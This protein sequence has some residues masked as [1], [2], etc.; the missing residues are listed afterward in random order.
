MDYPDVLPSTGSNSGINTHWVLFKPSTET[1][2]ELLGRYLTT[3]FFSGAGGWDVMGIDNFSGEYGMK[4]FLAHYA[5]RVLNGAA[6]GVLPRCTYGNDNHAPTGLDANGDSVCYDTGDCQD[7][8]DTPMADVKVIKMI[9][10]CG[11]PWECSFDESWDAK[12]KETCEG[13]HR[14]WFE[15]RA[16]FEETCWIGSPPPIKRDGDFKKDIFLGYCSCA[17]PACYETMIHDNPTAEPTSTPSSS[18]SLR[19]SSSPTVKPKYPPKVTSNGQ[20]GTAG[21]LPST[22][23]NPSFETKGPVFAAENFYMIMHEDNLYGWDTTAYDSKVEVWHAGFQREQSGAGREP[24]DGEY[25]VEL[26]ANEPAALWQKVNTAGANAVTIG[27]AHGQRGST[28]EQISVWV[29]NTV[30]PQKTS[31]TEQIDWAAQGYTRVVE[32]ISNALKDWDQY[33][34][35]VQIPTGQDETYVL[36]ETLNGLSSYGNFLD[37]IKLSAASAVSLDS[38]D[39]QL[40]EVDDVNLEE[41]VITLTNAEAGDTLGFGSLLLAGLKSTTTVAN[42]ALEIRVTGSAPLAVYQSVVNGI[43]FASSSTVAGSRV[44]Q[45]VVSDGDQLESNIEAIIIEYTV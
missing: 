8:R 19:P 44:I 38:F 22:V 9:T 23:L 28:N 10:T 11:A 13:F 20:S 42:R 25:Y 33:K 40:F 29:G 43:G 45:I 32:T 16:L 4:G 37:D 41:A 30:P 6:V 18:P 24:D 12:T 31:N 39:I 1:K 27:F 2:A 21:F 34:A 17:S 26:N 7:C 5:S 14:E 3:G 36:F 35:T 15:R